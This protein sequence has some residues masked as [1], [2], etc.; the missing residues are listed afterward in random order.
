MVAAKTLQE[1][2]GVFPDVKLK[3]HDTANWFACCYEGVINRIRVKHWGY[4]TPIPDG[5]IIFM[6]IIETESVCY[7]NLETFG[8]GCFGCAPNHANPSIE[9]QSS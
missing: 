8:D 9:L 6:A 4:H 7:Q 1:R 5:T 3:T 2:A